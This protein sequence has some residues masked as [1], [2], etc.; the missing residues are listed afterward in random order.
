MGSNKTIK[1]EF[2]FDRPKNVYS[3]ILGYSL[4]DD[5]YYLFFANK[6]KSKLFISKI[7]QF[8]LDDILSKVARIS[9]NCHTT[10][11]T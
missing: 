7:L 11:E 8:Q 1:K 2:V 9:L 3:E 6:Y 4:I 5:D 10:S